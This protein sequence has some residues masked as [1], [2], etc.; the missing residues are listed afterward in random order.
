M[1][2]ILALVSMVVSVALLVAASLIPFFYFRNGR[3][4]SNV[5]SINLLSLCNCFACGVFLATCFLGLI[6]HTIGSERILR[7]RLFDES[8]HVTDSHSGSETFGWHTLIDTNLMILVGFLLILLL[9][10]SVSLCMSIVHRNGGPSRNKN[11]SRNGF[12]DSNGSES[13]TMSRKLPKDRKNTSIENGHSGIFEPLVEIEDNLLDSSDSEFDTNERIEFRTRFPEDAQLQLGHS[14]H[15]NQSP[16]EF[17]KVLFSIMLHEVLCSFSYGVNL[18]TRRVSAKLAVFSSLF[19]ALSI[20]IGMAIMAT[21]GALEGTD[22]F[23][24]KFVLEGLSAGIFIYVASVEMLAHELTHESNTS[25]PK[26]GMCKALSVITGAFVAF[27]VS[28]IKL[29]HNE[30]VF[31]D[32]LQFYQN[33]YLNGSRERTRPKE[34]FYE[35]NEPFKMNSELS[36]A[37]KSTRKRK[38]NNTAPSFL[39]ENHERV[40]TAF[41]KFSSLHNAICTAEQNTNNA[42][43]RKA[44]K[45]AP[46]TSN[47]FATDSSSLDMYDLT[48]ETDVIDWS[49]VRVYSN[50]TCQTLWLKDNLGTCYVIPRKASFLRGDIGMIRHFAH[51][52]MKF[53]LIVTDPPWPNK[54]VKRQKCYPWMETDDI[55]NAMPIPNLLARGGLVCFWLSNSESIHEK[56][57]DMLTN[58]WGLVRLAEWFWLKIC[59]S[60]Q[61]VVK[62]DRP[63]HK[64]PFESLIFAC[65]EDDAPLLKDKITDHFTIIGVPNAN[66][67]RKPPIKEL[68]R[69]LDIFQSSNCLELFARYLLPE[70]TSIGLEVLKFQNEYFFISDN[71]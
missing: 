1:F 52:E 60:G 27:V 15:C 18:T 47:N 3:P 40:L 6:P 8:S 71:V 22:G 32:E 13:V 21:L 10:Q 17:F 55:L 31:F 45:D 38:S 37:K 61:P 46:S 62:F 36:V 12:D 9:E 4:K 39:L 29:R 14:H 50:R 63:E 26:E 58:Q 69:E 23:I 49:K 30:F 41:N 24:V 67:S 54:S 66:P 68:L 64:V 28:M 34:I 48:N 7:Q 20:P 11:Y 2:T 19:L 43:A 25:D 51:R 70:T 42:H 35:I 53:D 16:H 65:H 33:L 56:I 5:V 44:V 59:R 57:E